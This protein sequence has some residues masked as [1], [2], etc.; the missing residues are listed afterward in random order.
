MNRGM[1]ASPMEATGEAPVPHENSRP[2]FH[3]Q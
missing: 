1:G 3:M 2:L